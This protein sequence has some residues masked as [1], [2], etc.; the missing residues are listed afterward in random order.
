ML[1]I[2]N[3]NFKIICNSQSIKNSLEHM[4][5]MKKNMIQVINNGIVQS[6]SNID[7]GKL[8]KFKVMFLKMIRIGLE[9]FYQT[10][11]HEQISLS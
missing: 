11:L 8:S 6:V 3:N 4:F 1:K 5:N 10:K 2:I 7:R 9:R